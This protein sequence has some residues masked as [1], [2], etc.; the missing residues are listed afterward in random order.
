MKKTLLVSVVFAFFI[1]CASANSTAVAVG[2]TKSK[3]LKTLGSPVMTL[4]NKQDGEIFVYAD[5]VFS[6]KGT[7]LA[8]SHYW[9]YNYVYIS[10][11]GK[12]TSKRQEKQNYPPQA[13]DSI[14]MEGLGLLT[15]K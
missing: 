9:H 2:E 8:G 7:R 5:Q 15:S 10:K 6:K 12:V 4:D 1:S 13:I 3:V 14:K 11:E